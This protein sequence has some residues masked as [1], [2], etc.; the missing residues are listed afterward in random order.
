VSVQYLRAI[1]AEVPPGYVVAHNSLGPARRLGTRGF[2]AW[3][4]APSDRLA[5]CDCGWAPELAAHYRVAR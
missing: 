2:R 5:A 4:A 3:L 1:P